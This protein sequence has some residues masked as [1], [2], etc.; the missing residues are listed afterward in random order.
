MAADLVQIMS[1][2]LLVYTAPF[3]QRGE[4]I[5]LRVHN[6]LPDLAQRLDNHLGDLHNSHGVAVAV[7]ETAAPSCPRQRLIID[8]VENPQ[9]NC[10]LFPALERRRD[11]KV[12][13]RARTAQFKRRKTL[14]R[15][16]IKRLTPH[17]RSCSTNNR[18]D[19]TVL[20]SRPLTITSAD[21]KTEALRKPGEGILGLFRTAFRS[22]SRLRRPRSA[23]LDAA[24]GA[25]LAQ[26]ALCDID[27]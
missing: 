5:T 21:T 3:R 27:P 14:S 19:M 15:L 16:H 1:P 7:G 2:E 23:R 6:V 13:Q 9:T 24:A 11:K 18:D 25:L 22:S 26:V 4:F 10:S 20:P 12:T 8:V 17:A